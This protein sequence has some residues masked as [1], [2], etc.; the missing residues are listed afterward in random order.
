MDVSGL[1]PLD[2]T[3]VCV[4]VFTMALGLLWIY[5]MFSRGV[6]PGALAEGDSDEGTPKTGSGKKG[7][8]GK[9]RGRGKEVRFYAIFVCVAFGET[10]R[11]VLA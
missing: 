8:S 7:A 10:E 6:P 1:W 2:V 5:V 3:T 11:S 4:A 9:G